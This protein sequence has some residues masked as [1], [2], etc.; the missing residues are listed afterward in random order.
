[1][2]L[3]R[4]T[5]VIQNVFKAFFEDVFT[6]ERLKSGFE[7][8]NRIIEIVYNKPE[9]SFIIDCRKENVK[10]I[11][12]TDGALKPDISIIMDWEIAHKFWMGNLDA[13]TAL[14][15]QQIRIKGDAAALLDLKPLFRET[16][17][18]YRK[19]VSE[20]VAEIECISEIV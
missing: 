17:E 14:F 15:T 3:T 10:F 8:L 12:N 6:N 4:N 7:N 18:I 13:V 1:M 5:E 20:R 16:S 11:P 9:M 2:A 19:V